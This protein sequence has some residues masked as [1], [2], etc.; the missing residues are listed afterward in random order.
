M[1]LRIIRE[2]RKK[3]QRAKEYHMRPCKRIYEPDEGIVHIAETGCLDQVTLC[4]ITDWLGCKKGVPTDADVTCKHCLE[5][6]RIVR[7]F[8]DPHRKR[9]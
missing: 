6:V 2:R 3:P 7:S 5:L 4:G 9:G 1:L 8:R